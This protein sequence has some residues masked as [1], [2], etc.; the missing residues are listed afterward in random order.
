MARPKSP[1]ALLHGPEYVGATPP[2]MA[3][4][5]VLA[6]T[7]LA[8][9]NKNTR[10]LA[11]RIGYQLP[12][13]STDPDLIQRDI[14]ANMRRSMDA[15]M[16]I[17]RG[18][19]VLKA[20]CEHGNFSTRLDALGI[21]PRVAQRFMQ[22]ATKLANATTSSHL[23]KALDSQSKLFEMLILDDEQLEELALTGQTGE[24][25]LDDVAKMSVRELRKALREARANSAAKDQRLS[26]LSAD[27][28]AT[29]VRIQMQTPSER[30]HELRAEAQS[31]AWEAEALLKG[32]L[33]AMFIA[34]RADTDAA[35]IDHRPVMSGLLRQIELQAR[36]LRDEFDLDTDPG[37][38]PDWMREVTPEE[39][40]VL[41]ARLAATAAAN[42]WKFDAAGKMIPLEA[43]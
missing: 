42:G 29:R 11:V 9:E 5:E 12:A 13:D 17:G 23:L 33:R 16:E 34:L 15:L 3:A 35:G 19:L 36:L 37:E 7:L 43:D 4:E 6:G 14:A 25:L 39:Q 2:D 32:K 30:S 20:A 22:A 31:C 38:M 21:E 27:L 1:P 10:S 28:D 8:E 18:L 24:L 40:A 41:D 26:N